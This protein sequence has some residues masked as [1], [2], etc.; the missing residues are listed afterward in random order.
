MNQIRLKI[1]FWNLSFTMNGNNDF[2]FN[3]RLFIHCFL[4]FLIEL[5][6]GF[7]SML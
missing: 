5:L 6:I 1:L 3:G 7:K 4:M 2:L